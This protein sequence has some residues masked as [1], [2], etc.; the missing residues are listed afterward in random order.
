MANMNYCRFENTANDLRDCVNA[1]DEMPD[2]E[3][4]SETEKD[5]ANEMFELCQNFVEIFK[6]SILPN[7]EK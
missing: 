2:F 7:L 4:L 5:A 6:Q 3:E 1:L